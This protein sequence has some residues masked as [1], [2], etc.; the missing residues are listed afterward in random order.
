MLSILLLL[1]AIYHYNWLKDWENPNNILKKWA[2]KSGCKDSRQKFDWKTYEEEQKKLETDNK[3]Y[4]EAKKL[5]EVNEKKLKELKLGFN[6]KDDLLKSPKFD[7]E[8]AKKVLEAHSSTIEALT[9][10]TS[11]EG[12]AEILAKFPKRFSIDSPLPR[13]FDYVDLV[14][15][16]LLN[17]KYQLSQGNFKKA[18]EST[19]AVLNFMEHLSLQRP[20]NLLVG[21]IHCILADLADPMLKMS[22]QNKDL[23]QDYYIQVIKKITAINKNHNIVQTFENEM[24]LGNNY[25]YDMENLYK[26]KGN[27][28]QLFWQ[29]FR[30][31]VNEEDGYFLDQLKGYVYHHNPQIKRTIYV[32]RLVVRK[33]KDFEKI[34]KEI[35]D[36]DVKKRDFDELPSMEFPFPQDVKMAK[37]YAQFLYSDFGP[38]GFSTVDFYQIR[39]TGLNL[40][41]I[42]SAIKLYEKEYKMLPNS[43]SELAPKFIAEVPGDPLDYYRP[44]NYIKTPNGYRLYSKG[45]DG[46]DQL[47]L[48]EFDRHYFEDK[49]KSNS[50]DIVFTY[51]QE[52]I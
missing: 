21:I 5:H 16:L 20:R 34:P 25:L 7:V 48:K 52:G 29:K 24:A 43:L 4:R 31:A 50:G 36:Y 10:A 26:K 30:E 6:I 9:K 17:V 42:A 13:Y 37:L 49:L 12:Y 44:Y 28:N 39:E 32:S 23:S 45:I 11:Q 47:G 19:L 8:T 15:L 46:I 18:E 2:F 3:L 41:L 22:I 40:L 27:Y 51:N 14:R 38:R 1:T 33:N 35:R